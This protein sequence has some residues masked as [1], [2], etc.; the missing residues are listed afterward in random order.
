MN[1]GTTAPGAFAGGGSQAP[2][3][4]CSSAAAREPARRRLVPAQH[5]VPSRPGRAAVHGASGAPRFRQ[6]VSLYAA[7]PPMA[8]IYGRHLIDTLHERVGEEEQLR[9]RTDLGK[10]GDKSDGIWGRSSATRA[11]ATATAASM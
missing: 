5:S 4:I 8:A 3:N 1:G 7:M 9:G 2:T 11:I 10:D 6:E